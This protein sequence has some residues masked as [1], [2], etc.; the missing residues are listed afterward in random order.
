MRGVFVLPNILANGAVMRRG[1]AGTGPGAASVYGEGKNQIGMIYNEES[2]KRTCD[3]NKII[4]TLILL[5]QQNNNK[6]V[7]K[8]YCINTR[9]MIVCSIEQE[10]KNLL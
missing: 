6:F 5:Y 1:I 3:I 2:N 7:L 8:I 10:F 4:C 9:S